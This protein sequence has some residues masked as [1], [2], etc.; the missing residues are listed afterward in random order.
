[1]KLSN[2]QVYWRDQL[3]GIIKWGIAGFLLVNGWFINFGDHIEFSAP[4]DTIAFQRACYLCVLVPG[5]MTLWVCSIHQIFKKHLAHVRSR[6]VLPRRPTMLF[7]ILMSV[8][9]IIETFLVCYF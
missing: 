7:A 6:T 2:E 1:M 3:N 8:T 9:L 5:I 4:G